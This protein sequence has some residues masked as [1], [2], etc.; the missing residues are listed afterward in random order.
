M[1]A[2]TTQRSKIYVELLAALRREI[3][4]LHR[5][6]E[7]ARAVTAGEPV[8]KGALEAPRGRSPS[9]ACS[10]RGFRQPREEAE[11]KKLVA[12]GPPEALEEHLVKMS[13]IAR[14]VGPILVRI[15]AHARDELTSSPS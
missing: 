13:A 6:G 10:N 3:A 1:R 4:L 5:L 11:R 7:A 2:F 8:A 12:E 9:D 14:D 15:E